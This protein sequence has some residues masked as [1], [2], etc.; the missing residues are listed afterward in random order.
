MFSARRW[1]RPFFL[2]AVVPLLA[3]A[4]LTGCGSP[5]AVSGDVTYEGQPVEQGQI[6]FY[7][8]D[9]KGPPAGAPISRGRYEVSGL[10]PGPKLVEI[11]ATRAVKFAHSSE[12][13]KQMSRAAGAKAAASGLIE[14][15]DA[16]PPNAE[17]NR[18]TV[19]VKAGRQTQDFVL[20]RPAPKRPSR[21]VR[22]S[23]H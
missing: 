6:T 19:E 14:S 7:P 13:L 17:G 1:R 18:V 5:C 23:P 11:T 2:P 3:A 8:A 15:A 4:L 22:L 12:E 9:G 21:A 16:I 20:S 10:V